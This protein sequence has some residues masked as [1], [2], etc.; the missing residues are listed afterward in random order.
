MQLNLTQNRSKILSAMSPLLDSTGSISGSEM[1][2]RLITTNFEEGSS[3]DGFPSLPQPSE[4]AILTNPAKWQVRSL[5]FDFL[6]YFKLLKTQNLGRSVLYTP[7]ITSTQTLFTGNLPFCSALTPD[8]G[9][10]SVATQ[11]TKGKGKQ[12]FVRLLMRKWI[13]CGYMRLYQCVCKML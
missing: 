1:S 5:S 10:V 6:E 9:V 4:L 8:M 12:C 11:Q 2:V 13:K 3:V 7:V